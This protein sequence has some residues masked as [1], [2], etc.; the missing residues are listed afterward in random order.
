MKRMTA[1]FLV[2]VAMAGC[3]GDDDGGDAGKPSSAASKT[4]YIARADAICAAANSKEAALGAPGPGWIYEPEFDDAGFLKRFNAA[5]REALR[6][7]QALEPPS[8]R[9]ER[10]TAMV[11]AIAQMVRSL[12]GRIA[13]LEA[14]KG[15]ASD[16]IKTYLDGYSNLTPAAAELGLSECQ[17][18]SL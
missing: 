11:A 13:D 14:G 17:G 2:A 8:A 15:D 9:R 7:L 1:L 5:G 6:K 4:N 3:G 10:A 16:R 18:V 12:D